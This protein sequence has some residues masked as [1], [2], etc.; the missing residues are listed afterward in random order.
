MK[1]RYHNP[2]TTLA[3]FLIALGLVMI[4]AK[5]DLLHIGEISDYFSWQMLL[6]FIGTYA[7]LS[8]ELVTAVLLFAIGI[9]FLMP[10]MN[11]Q[12]SEPYRKIYWPAIL[13]LT[14]LAFII[15]GLIKRLFKQ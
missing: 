11:L 6:L 10:E 14:G 5:L 3:K 8:F 15:G 4:I 1:Q 2:Y 13:V 9:W 7:L 12:L